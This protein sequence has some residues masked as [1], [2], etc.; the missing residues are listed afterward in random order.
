MLHVG[1]AA[2]PARVRPLSREDAP[3]T[4]SGDDAEAGTRTLRLTLRAPLP[5]RPGD[6]ALLRDPGAH[7]SWAG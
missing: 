2:V 4:V 7:A 3:D 1:S 5:L 6:R